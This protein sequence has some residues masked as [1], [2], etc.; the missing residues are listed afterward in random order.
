MKINPG[1]VRTLI[2]WIAWPT[3]LGLCLLL[4]GFGFTVDA[5]VIFFNLAFISLFVMLYLLECAMPHENSW[6]NRDGQ[7]FANISHTLMVK[8]TVQMLVVFSGAI[9]LASLVTSVT[10]DG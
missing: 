4:T 2:S 10:D 3:L 8:G 1:P 5:P 9:G 7:T 6:N